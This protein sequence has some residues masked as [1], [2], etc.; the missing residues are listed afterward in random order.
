MRTALFS[1]NNIIS[2]VFIKMTEHIK[3]ML[4]ST[5]VVQ[6][7]KKIK[8]SAFH[9][10]IKG[11][12]ILL[13]II[14]QPTYPSTKLILRFRLYSLSIAMDFHTRFVLR[15]TRTHQVFNVSILPERS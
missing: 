2:T 4:R 15:Y 5:N 12:L 13:Y 9:A 3:M 6:E 14:Y 8:K 10:C 7:L 11:T 1:K